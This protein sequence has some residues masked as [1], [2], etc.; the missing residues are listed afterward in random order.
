MTTQ[1]TDSVQDYDLAASGLFDR[2][3]TG[4]LVVDLQTKL[5]PVIH[6]REEVLKR[7]VQAI[8][9]AGHLDLPIIVTEQYVKGLGPTIPEVKDALERFDAYKP[10]EKF[11]F[12]CFGES[13]VEDVIEEAGINALALVGIEGHV[14]VMQTAIDALDREMDV[15][16]LAE[17]IGS[18][19]PRHKEDAIHRVRDFGAVVGSN[20][21]FAFEMMRTSKHPKFKDIQKSIV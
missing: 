21:M 16:Y 14:C 4:L 12:S 11:A 18:R 19:N 8:E 15:Y 10:I 5:F 13:D 7:T 17:A 2:D 9:I 3:D 20:E 6:D 1:G